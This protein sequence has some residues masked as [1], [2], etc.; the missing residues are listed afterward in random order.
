M[1]LTPTTLRPNKIWLV[2]SSI[3]VFRAW[4]TWP[5]SLK[6]KDGNC[7][8]AVHGFL[9]FVY[10]LLS[11]EQPQHIGF[12]FDESLKHSHRREIYPDY[13]AH[14]KSAP[15]DLRYQFNLC[16]KFLKALGII[17][18]SSEYYEA[19]DIIGTVASHYQKQSC[20]VILITADKDLAQLIVGDDL[21]WEYGN[22]KKMDVRAVQKNFGVRPDQIADLLAIAGDKSDNI[23][24][25]PDIGMSTASK[26]LKRFGSLDN[27]IKSSMEIGKTK[28]RRAKYLQNQIEAHI[29]QMR[30]A[31]Q[32]TGIV[33]NA[34]DAPI[35]QSFNRC[36]AKPNQKA[37]WKLF[38]QLEYSDGERQK[39]LKL[40]CDNK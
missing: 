10:Q 28:I 35:H 39:W 40:A 37:L 11:Q 24:G 31:R 27:L 7:V 17:E 4:F 5:K 12:A 36:K 21:W 30:L 3:Y 32:L 2:D 15:L 16:R 19:D 29:D 1:Q 9:H 33:C 22:N 23:P 18:F 13:K 14:R 6:D 26:L 38:D 8:N 34:E 25:V 20:K